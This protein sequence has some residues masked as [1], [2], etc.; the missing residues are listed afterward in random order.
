MKRTHWWG[1]LMDRK[2]GRAKKAVEEREKKEK[3]KRQEGRG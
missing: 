2:E 1:V 3:V